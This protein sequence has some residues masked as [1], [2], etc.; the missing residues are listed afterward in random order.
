[1]PYLATFADLIPRVLFA[2]WSPE[3]IGRGWMVQEPPRRRSL[4]CP[5][6]RRPPHFLAG[7]L[8]PARHDRE[9]RPLRGAALHQAV[10]GGDFSIAHVART[11]NT[12]TA[13]V[14]YV[15]SQHP[16]GWSPPRL[17]RNRHTATRVGQWRVWYE[18]DLP[19]LQDIADRE[20]T[21]LA[22]VRLAL[23]VPADGD[24]L[25]GVAPRCASVGAANPPVN[26][27]LF[28]DEND[29]GASSPA[30]PRPRPSPRQ[31]PAR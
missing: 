12:T 15:L 22:T 31:F 28:A 13:H 20:G 9:G 8:R 24:G 25:P 29:A 6:R 30:T 11:L 5:P 1:M 14:T 2:D 18:Q 7:L 4:S 10:P 23:R 26:H 19:S 16:V 17:H 21:S 27:A 3:I